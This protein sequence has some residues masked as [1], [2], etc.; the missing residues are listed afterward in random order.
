[1][2]KMGNNDILVVPC[3]DVL[4]NNEKFDLTCAVLM[5]L[6]TLWFPLAMI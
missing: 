5:G 3:T 1:M 6:I 2:N 4:G